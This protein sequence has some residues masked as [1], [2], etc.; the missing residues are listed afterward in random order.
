MNYIQ[1][2][3]LNLGIPSDNR[4]LS[5]LRGLRSTIQLR[6]ICSCSAIPK[7]GLKLGR[8]LSTLIQVTKELNGTYHNVFHMT[9]GEDIAQYGD[10]YPSVW[11]NK[12]KN[13]HISSAVSGDLNYATDYPYNL[14]Q[15]YHIEI[16]QKENSNGEIIYSI[17]IDDLTVDLDNYQSIKTVNT[18]PQR[19]EKVILYTSDPWYPSFASFGELKDLSIVNL[20]KFPA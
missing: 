9:I 11:V 20:D 6:I 4:G 14:N 3:F 17:E 7:P 2:P 8:T 16:L 19:F 15:W 18:Q 10:A 1:L 5:S 12:G 13:F